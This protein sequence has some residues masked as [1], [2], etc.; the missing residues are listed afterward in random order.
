[1]NAIQFIQSTLFELNRSLV[2][3][4]EPLTTEQMLYRPT[5]E[6]NS[7]S[8][9][10]WHFSRSEDGTFHRISTIDGTPTVWERDG[11]YERFGLEES[12]SGSGFTPDQVAALKPDKDSLVAYVE[13]IRQSV[14]DGLSIMTDDDLDRPLNPDNP[15]LT[16]G[17]QI[18][19][20]VVGHGFFHLGEIRFLKGLQGMPFPR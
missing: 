14:N 4:V 20:I 18:Q 15:R 3:E 11:W 10:L 8:F 19:S 2:L 5:P 9:L 6:A 16:V 12:R 13:S 17:R 7:I 1:M